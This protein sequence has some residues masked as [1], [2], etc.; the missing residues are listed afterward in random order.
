[1]NNQDI[2]RLYDAFIQLFDYIEHETDD[3]CIKCPYYKICFGF[4][5]HEFAASLKR[6]KE[7]IEF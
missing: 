2:G 5:G 6:I 7:A 3:G 4:A 1:M